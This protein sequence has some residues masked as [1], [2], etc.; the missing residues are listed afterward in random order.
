MFR[1]GRVVIPAGGLYEWLSEG[2]RKQPWYITRKDR[3]PIF[4]ARDNELQA[5]RPSVV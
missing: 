5:I 4:M 1:E 3:E 2:G